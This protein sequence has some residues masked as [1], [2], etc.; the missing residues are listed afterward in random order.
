MTQLQEVAVAM[1]WGG[2][3]AR[4][5]VVDRQA[6]IL[7]RSQVRNAIGGDRAQMLEAAGG[8]VQQAIAWADKRPIAGVG[9]ALA[10]PVDATTGTLYGSPHLSP[11]NGV[12]LKTLWEPVLGQRVW[13]GNDANL[14]ALGEFH[15][16]AGRV[17]LD[18]GHPP[19][20]LVYLTVS[21]GI[22]GGVVIGGD[23]FLG[24]HGLAAEI[25]HMVIDRSPGAPRCDCSHLG[26]LEAL[27][28]GTAIARFAR[29]RTL[30]ETSIIPSLAT[31]G[32]GEITS[33]TVF[34]AAGED[35]ALAWSILEDAVQAL[36]V[37]LTNILHL[38]DPDLIVLGGGVTV[39]SYGLDTLGLLPR[40]QSLML[41]RA[42]SQQY[43]ECLLVASQLGDAP[44]L[45][46]AATLVWKNVGTQRSVSH[47]GTEIRGGL[48]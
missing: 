47:G 4:A 1:D 36:A 29:E 18:Q 5:A 48:T 46:G 45:I 11:L 31:R 26:C 35:D 3:W 28:S 41:S 32:N 19:R 10:G 42:M 33:E 24:A 17:E 7:W 43:K 15:Y 27:A 20:I 38:Y 23:V 30:S 2:T 37:G 44:G 40:I 8:L 13:V 22:G 39:G 25:G 16:G 14:S 12:S 21:T 34:Q 6:A 9:I